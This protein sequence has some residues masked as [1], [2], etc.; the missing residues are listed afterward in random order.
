MCSE[1][2]GGTGTGRGDAPGIVGIAS[3]PAGTTVRREQGAR[4]A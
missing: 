1:R 2:C 4:A 3:G